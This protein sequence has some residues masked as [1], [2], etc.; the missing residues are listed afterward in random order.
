M[1]R[2]IYQRKEYSIYKVSNGYIVHN[3]KKNFKEGHTH[4]N[5]YF[6]A[7]SIIDLAVR[8]KMPKKANKWEIESLIRIN[9]DNVYRN[10]L[11]IIKERFKNECNKY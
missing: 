2:K 4:I 1:S 3:T 8:K 6:K 11:L 10:K 9:N 5:N 7:K